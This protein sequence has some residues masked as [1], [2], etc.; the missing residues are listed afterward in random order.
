MQTPIAVEA[1]TGAQL[2][3]QS[4]QSHPMQ[5]ITAWQAFQASQADQRRRKVYRDIAE[6]II[7]TYPNGEPHDHQ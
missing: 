3:P 2:L 6:R 7:I 4:E 5:K 1:E